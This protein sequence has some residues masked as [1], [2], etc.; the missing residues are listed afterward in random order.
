MTG[1][2]GV[3]LEQYLGGSW[4]DL[5][6]RLMAFDDYGAPMEI[7][8]GVGE[9]GDVTPGSF[10]LTLEN[11]DG[12]L[13]PGRTASSYYP[14][15]TR[16]RAIRL[17]ALISGAW[18]GRFAGYVDTE[19]LTWSNSPATECAVTLTCTDAIGLAAG[20]TLR[21]VAV[22]ATAARGPVAYWPLTDSDTAAA[23][24]QSANRQPSLAQQQMGSGGEIGWASGL[25][26]PTDDAGG[27]VFTPATAA[28]IWLRT[29]TGIDLPTSWSVTVVPSPVTATGE[30]DGY[31]CQ[32]GTDAY[33]IGIWYDA[34][35]NKFS[36]IETTLD[37]SGDPIDYVLSTST[38]AWTGGMETLTV[39]PTTV[40]LGSSGTTGSRHDTDQM[41]DALV[42][43]G[44]ASVSDSH[45]RLFNGEIKHLAIWSGAVPAGL[46]TDT[47][48]GPADMFLMSTA[49]ATVM[50]WAGVPVAVV[51]LGTDRVVTLAKTEGIS[52]VEQ[53]TYY[54]QGSLARIFIDGDGQLVIAASDYAPDPVVAPSAEISPD[55]EWGADPA[56][57]VASAVMSWPDGTTY[58]ATSL[59][60]SGTLEMPGV[61][62]QA[63]GQQVADW[64]ASAVDSHPRFPAAPFDLLT[65]EGPIG[66]LID[67]NTDTD[68]DVNGGTGTDGII[69][70]G[71]EHGVSVARLALADIADILEIP[72]LPGQ[73]PSTTETGLVDSIVETLGVSQWTRQFTTS[74]DQRD[75]ALIVGDPT[76]GRVTAGYLAAPLGP[77]IDGAGTAWRAGDEI[78]AAKLNANAYPGVDMQAGRVTITPVANTPTSIAVTFPRPFAT[79]PKVVVTADASL[80]GSEVLGAGATSITTTGFTAWIYRTNTT[81]GRL[82]W[83]A[84]V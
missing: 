38:S 30:R 49:A 15:L 41:L 44:C 23:A 20:R 3:L 8:R 39:T 9:A 34:S 37:S 40:K 51:P 82:N 4:V 50:S 17:K 56:G 79:A 7:T 42:S 35:T 59:T 53:L 29:N 74:A 33:S 61:L 52:A 6:G 31:V 67:G 80:P 83:I 65:I 14:N 24:D 54:A 76:R 70:G 48:T 81:V 13:T 71:T 21:S 22:E 32:L 25:I 63:D 18:H 78:T 69:D 11:N 36:A 62:P 57:D 10:T 45:G 47:L 60:G 12:E 26:L 16:F 75:R 19:P 77:V 46:A 1:V 68:G 64:V 27:V 43:V 28:G 84:T 5:T 2:P 72:G 66:D 73:L 58:T 55:V